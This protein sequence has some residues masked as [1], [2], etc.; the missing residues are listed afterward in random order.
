MENV[1]T[2]VVINIATSAII[3]II[4]LVFLF[5]VISNITQNYYQFDGF[6]KKFGMLVMF[7][8]F[9]TLIWYGIQIAPVLN[10]SADGASVVCILAFVYLLIS[11][12]VTD[13]EIVDIL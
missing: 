12:K 5:F 3:G 7:M 1:I 13:N 8:L 6:W 2:F 11:C 9:I 4:C 10:L